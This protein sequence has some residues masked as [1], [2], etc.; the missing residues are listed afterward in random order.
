MKYK[1]NDEGNAHVKSFIAPVKRLLEIL[2]PD[3]H[4]SWEERG[5]YGITVTQSASLSADELKKGQSFEI[6]DNVEIP[7]EFIE[8]D[9]EDFIANLEADLK[10]TEDQN[11][12]VEERRAIAKA[13]QQEIDKAITEEIGQK[14][15][16]LRDRVVSDEP[17]GSILPDLKE[18]LKPGV[19]EVTG[20][21]ELKKFFAA[22]AGEEGHVERYVLIEETWDG[23]HMLNY[24]VVEILK[25]AGIDV[26][27]P[28]QSGGNKFNFGDTNA[29]VYID[30]F[31]EGLGQKLEDA[32]VIAA[33][34]RISGFAKTARIEVKDLLSAIAQKEGLE[35]I[36]RD[37]KSQG[38]GEER[39]R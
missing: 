26:L 32:H 18:F 1:L 2:H 4:Y 5:M 7:K 39:E 20:I 23:P 30:A 17:L 3:I 38:D 13:L 27:E 25:E 15:Q 24:E 37:G 36:F 12:E 35:A 14:A 22:D 8:V 28:D 6:S 19:V 34:R 16:K 21:D 31:Q 33:Q 9:E 11:E 29:F 10:A